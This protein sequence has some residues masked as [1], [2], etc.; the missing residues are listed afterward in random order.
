MI[1]N[2]GKDVIKNYFAGQV[3]QIGGAISVG[4]GATAAALTS[5]EL[6]F[7]TT[8]LI[9][10]SVSADLANNRIVYKAVLPPGMIGTIYE[11]GLFDRSVPNATLNLGILG[12]TTTWNA[13]TLVATNARRGTTTLKV[14]AGASA[15]VVAAISDQSIDLSKFVGTDSVVLAFQSGA[16]LSAVKLRLGNAPGTYREFNFT[17]FATGYNTKRVNLSA[18]T[19]TGTVDL[20]AI[21]Y[22]ALVVTATSGGTTS[23]YL[24]GIKVEDNTDQSQLVAMTVLSTPQVVSAFIPTEIEYSLGITV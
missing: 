4:T 8:R 23:V 14:D 11:I 21:T 7:E 1:T 12:G 15:T 18:G 17:G 19:D 2:L 10:K 13:G 20:S 5:T 9:V 3:G 22:V 24:D 16:N 6:S